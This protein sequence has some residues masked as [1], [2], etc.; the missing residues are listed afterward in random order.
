MND[1]L[2]YYFSYLNPYSYYVPVKNEE[3][4]KEEKLKDQEKQII[5][6]KKYFVQNVNKAFNFNY[7]SSIPTPFA[8]L[9]IEELEFVISNL[10]KTN[11]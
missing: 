8:N 3:K 4:L 6:K 10:K 5:Q 11:K 1:S 9:T 2:Y 7:S